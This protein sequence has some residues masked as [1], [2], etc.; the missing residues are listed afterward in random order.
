MEGTAKTP[1]PAKPEPKFHHINKKDVIS[2]E[3][4]D[5]VHSESLSRQKISRCARN[6]S[7]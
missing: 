3:G 1:N 4:R 5:L 7:L 6:D 2:T